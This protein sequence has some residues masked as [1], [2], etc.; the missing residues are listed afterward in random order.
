Q[1]LAS[2]FPLPPRPERRYAVCV[3]MQTAAIDLHAQ[4]LLEPHVAE[5]HPRAEVVEQLELALLGR[6]LEDGD[7]HSP[8]VD[9]GLGELEADLAAV[10][11]HAHALRAFSTFDHDLLVARFHALTAAVNQPIYHTV[12]E[13]AGVPLAHCDLDGES[14][15]RGQA[16]DFVGRVPRLG[17]A[18]AG[19]NAL[20]AHRTAQLQV[21]RQKSQ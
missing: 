7:V 13:G 18:F 15:L 16:A 19:L 2:R 20:D 10:I 17:E 11:E 14:V 6:G 5:V 4:H 21:A 9:E 8:C 1:I 12:V 3:R